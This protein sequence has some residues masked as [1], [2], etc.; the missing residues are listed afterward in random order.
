MEPIMAGLCDDYSG[1]TRF[2]SHVDLML[3]FTNIT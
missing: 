3:E 1:T 2:V